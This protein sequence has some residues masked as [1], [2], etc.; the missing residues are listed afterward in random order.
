MKRIVF[1]S[2]LLAL[3]SCNSE[4]TGLGPPSDP[5]TETF[6]ASLAIDIAQMVRLPSGV[7]TQDI[8]VGTG[9]SVTARSDTVWLTYTGF[10]K[11]GS[12]FDS[13][14]NTRFQPAF[15]VPGFRDG[16]MGLR[17]GGR[18]KIVIP[19]SQGYGG[20]SVKDVDGS[21]RIPRQS[22]LVFSVEML[23]VNNVPVPTT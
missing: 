10:L 6:A 4:I 3:A 1:L 5:A 20:A 11:D 9:D 21:I 2:A 13:G 18:R 22:T 12:T 23:R 7:Y 14:T 16:L 17:V 15:L 19:S 8:I